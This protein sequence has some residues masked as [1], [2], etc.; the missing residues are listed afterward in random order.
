MV[1]PAPQANKLTYQAIKPFVD[2]QFWLEFTRLKLDVWK[3][4]APHVPIVA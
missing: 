1:D 3:L 2:L 4:E